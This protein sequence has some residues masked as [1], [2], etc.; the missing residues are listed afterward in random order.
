MYR[1]H[2]IQNSFP[3]YIMPLSVSAKRQQALC[4]VILYFLKIPPNSCLIK[5]PFIFCGGNFLAWL[6]TSL[7][8]QLWIKQGSNT[9]IILAAAFQ[10]TT[11]NQSSHPFRW[12]C[13]KLISDGRTKVADIM[14][15]YA[16]CDVYNMDETGNSFLS[17]LHQ[18]SLIR[19]PLYNARMIYS[20]TSD[21][22]GWTFFLPLSLG[23]VAIQKP[24]SNLKINC[25]HCHCGTKSL[26]R[27]VDG[28][29][30][31]L[32]SLSIHDWCDA[33]VNAIHWIELLLTILIQ[34]NI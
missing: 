4:T 20:L 19:H 7:V 3:C 32:G 22:Q 18:P 25:P 6:N 2:S 34:I 30:D 23:T 27:L 24:L 10:I 14:G 11:W 33:G 12:E 31:P 29:T 15:N 8:R 21:S 9:D 13:Q 1:K 16:L 26:K 5:I 17:Q 28:Y